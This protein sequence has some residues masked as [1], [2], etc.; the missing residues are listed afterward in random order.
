M[1]QFVFEIGIE[2]MPARFVPGLAEELKRLLAGELLAAKIDFARIATAGTPRRLT[3]HLSGV[4]AVQKSEE[5]IV[6]GPPVKVARDAEGNLTKAGLGFAKSQNVDVAEV[7]ELDTAKGRYLAVKKQAGG[8]PTLAILPG[9]LAS[10][11]KSLSFPKKMRWGSFEFAFGR[12]VRWLLALL[13]EAVVPVALEVCA[14]DRLTFGHRVMGPG[15]HVVASAAA[16]VT[17]I[18]EQGKVVLDPAERRE[19]IRAHG[20]ELAAAKGGSVIANERLLDE[21]ANLVEYPLPILGSFDARYLALPREVLLTSM[22]SHQKSFGVE[23]ASGNL[24]PH[25]LTVLNLEPKDIDLVRKGWERVLRARLE[26]ARFFW[27]SDIATDFDTWREGLEHVT[28]LA[29]LGSMG[30]KARRLE[31]LCAF[32]AGRVKPE[33]TLDLSQAGRLAKCDLVSDMV[34][35]F[36]TLQGVMGGIYARR[37]GEAEAVWQAISEH[38]LPV[39]PDSPVPASLPGALLALA[40]KADSLA[41][42]F[43]LGLIPTGGADPYALRRQALG[44]CRILIEHGLRLP[45]SELIDAA[46][47]GYAGVSLKIAPGTARTQLLDFFAQRLK[48]YFGGQGHETLV[49]EAALGGGFDDVW[50]LSRRIAVLGEFSRAAGFQAAVL[51]FKRA[52]NIIRKQGAEAGQELNGFYS[53]ELFEAEAERTLGAALAEVAPRFEAYWAADDFGAILGLLEE[54]RPAVDGFFDKVMVMAEDPRV[55]LNRLNLLQA[56]VALLSR[57]ADFASLQV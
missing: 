53:P 45:L 43:G 44:I 31:K 12:P 10:V 27:E 50:A 26:D 56:L 23:D 29:G 33:L 41:G 8:Q 42:C 38:Y 37:K 36:D 7:F 57:V 46:F 13:D 48:A 17:V 47:A 6:T 4:A 14:A 34:G 54:L 32:L 51:T 24:K 11:V 35:E 39:G 55:R 25:F 18:R 2:E 49:V 15:P 22:E 19:L 30:D 28:F 20:A 16:Y 9:I 52:A 21:V 3:A 5:E 1:P 40:D